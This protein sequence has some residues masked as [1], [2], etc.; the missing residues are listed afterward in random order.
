MNKEETIEELEKSAYDKKL[1]DQE[2]K[3]IKKETSDFIDDLQKAKEELKGTPINLEPTTSDTPEELEEKVVTEVIDPVTGERK[4]T[5][6]PNGHEDHK[7]FEEI[8]DDIN[9][10]K[11]ADI[12][13]GSFVTESDLL[14]YLESAD[15]SILGELYDQT[16]IDSEGMRELIKIINRRLKGEEFNVYKSLPENIQ[17][18]IRLFAK[19]G[20]YINGCPANRLNSLYNAISISF[21]DDFISEIKFDRAK[22]DFAR[23][24][25]Y[26]YN[27][28]AK[29]L[30]DANLEYV[31]DRNKIYREAADKID[32]EY[33]RNKLIAILDTIDSARDIDDLKK[34][35]LKCRIKPIEIEK[36]DARVYSSF[37]SKYKDS[38]NNIYDI[39]LAES[40]LIRHMDKLGYTPNQCR[41][42]L[43]CFCK[44]V[45]NYSV[46]NPIMHAYM[47]YVLYY[48]AMLDADRSEKFK[49][50]V[51]MVIDNLLSHNNIK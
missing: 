10:Y 3:D 34:F 16:G 24:L 48:C 32:D 1:S 15:S 18:S 19:N 9:K 28:A 21:I 11:D 37:L 8:I 4:Y 29:E 40:V 26:L 51:A 23:E 38:V 20:G 6:A 43:I 50:N 42:F 27:D 14:Q 12:L 2:I 47:Y 36:V 7:T 13:G 5:A 41:A 31:E 33:K 22:N 49:N 25:E 17:Q 46:D 44:Y 30:S 39:H 45:K 35:A